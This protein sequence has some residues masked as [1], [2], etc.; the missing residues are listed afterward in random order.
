[1][2]EFLMF[3]EQARAGDSAALAQLFQIAGD[4]LS[5][6]PIDIPKLVQ[7]KFSGSDV[8][9]I[10]LGKVLDR[11]NTFN[12]KSRAEFEAW[13]R[14]V[15]RN[16]LTDELR[17]AAAQ[18]RDPRRER[19]MASPLIADTSTPSRAMMRKEK[20][21]SLLE[22]IDTLPKDQALAVR[23]I[24]LSHMAIA[25][26]AEVLGKTE[27]AVAGLVKRGLAKLRKRMKS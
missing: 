10:S 27:S 8:R 13:V 19:D 17:R 18:G 14:V 15:A 16:T 24:Y 7:P 5:T 22:F 25:D 1:M 9:Q 21:L 11:L 3:V 4:V 12:G 23:L 2:D 20:I 6:V 26:V